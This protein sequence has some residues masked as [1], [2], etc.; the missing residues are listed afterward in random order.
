MC[1]VHYTFCVCVYAITELCNLSQ[2]QR[3]LNKTNCEFEIFTI[4]LIRLHTT[5]DKVF[6]S[7]CL[8]RI[9]SLIAL[10]FIRFLIYTNT[11]FH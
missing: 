6:V 8:R 4:Y 1:S 7:Y 2:L 10:F 11:Q 9:Y 3:I 5:Y